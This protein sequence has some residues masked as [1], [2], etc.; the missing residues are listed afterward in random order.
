MEVVILTAHFTAGA[1]ELGP[2]GCRTAAAGSH[3]LPPPARPVRLH[4]Q[5]RQVRPTA[6]HSGVP[7]LHCT[8]VA[9]VGASCLS[10]GPPPPPPSPASAGSSSRYCAA[11]ECCPACSPAT[12]YPNLAT[13]APLPRQTGS[14]HSS[15]QAEPGKRAGAGAGAGAAGLLR[16]ELTAAQ[17][18]VTSLRQEVEQKENIAALVATATGKVFTT[19]TCNTS[20]HFVVQFC[21]FV[22][23]ERNICW[24]KFHWTWT[25][26]ARMQRGFLNW[27]QV[28]F[29][30]RFQN[31]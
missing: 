24:F 23:L 20:I 10:A 27:T 15:Q 8:A 1:P 26:T 5:P 30:W 14:V 21:H 29:V 28:L 19:N 9:W 3:L 22:I 7:V 12:V 16:A 13:A 25:D 4:H 6:L 31:E 11:G 18:L 2:G 17:A